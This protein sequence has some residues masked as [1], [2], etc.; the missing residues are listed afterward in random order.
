MWY[1]IYPPIHYALNIY[2]Y[3]YAYAICMLTAFAL[4]IT[5][6]DII[7]FKPSE[8]KNVHRSSK[9]EERDGEKG[10]NDS[11]TDK[12]KKETWMC[13]NWCVHLLK[14]RHFHPDSD[15][16]WFSSRDIDFLF[17]RIPTTTTTTTH[18][19]SILP[20]LSS[21]HLKIFCS[22]RLCIFLYLVSHGF[23]SSMHQ[24]F[25]SIIYAHRIVNWCG[26]L[27]WNGAKLFDKVLYIFHSRS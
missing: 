4:V 20:L 6:L 7:L 10:K 8:W 1:S 2:T 16:P 15:R 25:D 26:G 21:L 22:I 23:S 12:K 19:P 27:K 3:T 11:K 18:C 24:W 9:C 14:L 5:W 17:T 13:N